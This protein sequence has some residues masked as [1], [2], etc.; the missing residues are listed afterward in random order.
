MQS[1]AEWMG[2]ASARAEGCARG[3]SLGSDLEKTDPR[4]TP[5]VMASA[6]PQGHLDQPHFVDDL[7]PG[8]NRAWIN[9]GSPRYRALRNAGY[10]IPWDQPG[11]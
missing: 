10:F 3:V 2:K 8:M 6:P 5:L 11:T 7:A 9:H 1:T 4:L